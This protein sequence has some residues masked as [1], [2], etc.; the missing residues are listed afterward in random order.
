MG[1]GLADFGRHE[2]MLP[3][4]LKLRLGQRRG[5]G[6]DITERKQTD[7]ARYRRLFEASNDGLVIADAR[8]GTI[9]E[10]NPRIPGRLLPGR[11][12]PA[13]PQG[14]YRQAPVEP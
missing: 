10:V 12:N 5:F 8:T 14:S 9:A 6:F 4:R 1:Q 13:Q 3:V 2:G 7:E 11:H